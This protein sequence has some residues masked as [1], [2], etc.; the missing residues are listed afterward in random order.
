MASVTFLAAS[1]SDIS[2]E[3]RFHVKTGGRI[4]AM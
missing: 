4:A 1:D 2:M 3:F